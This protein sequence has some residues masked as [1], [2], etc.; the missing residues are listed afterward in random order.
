[1][2][3]SRAPV[4]AEAAVVVGVLL[5]VLC[6]GLWVAGLAAALVTTVAA[7]VVLARTSPEH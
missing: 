4:G 7:E 6:V 5:A 2:G 1:M 3:A